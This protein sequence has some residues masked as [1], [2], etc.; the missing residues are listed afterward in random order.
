VVPV[1]QLLNVLRFVL[2]GI[3]QCFLNT[4]ERQIRVYGAGLALHDEQIS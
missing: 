3:L 4:V 1:V 2:W